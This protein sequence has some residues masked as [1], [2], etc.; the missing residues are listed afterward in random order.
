MTTPFYSQC[1]VWGKPK[2]LM[3]FTVIEKINN[4]YSPRLGITS[5]SRKSLDHFNYF[6]NVLA[7]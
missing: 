3:S 7:L 5:C 6:Y 2:T 4:G 1:T